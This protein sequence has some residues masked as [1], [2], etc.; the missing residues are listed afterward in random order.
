MS[1][2][3]EVSNLPNFRHLSGMTAL[4][5]LP[6]LLLA[7]C[8]AAAAPA[9][10][11]TPAPTQGLVGSWTST[12]TKE[13]L[14]RVMPDFHKEALC[15]NAGTFDWTFNADGTFTADQTALPDCPTPENTHIEDTWSADG[16]RVAFAKGTPDEEVYEWAVDGDTLTFKHV[17]GECI[18]CKAINTANPWK[19]VSTTP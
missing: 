8:T 1:R 13:D 2:T 10:T 3:R 12:V 11:A 15:D 6:M 17:S 9:P 7:S 19:R 16:N 5:L 18:P 14:L 4:L